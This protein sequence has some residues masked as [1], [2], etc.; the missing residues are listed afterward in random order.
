M[1]CMSNGSHLLWCTLSI[2]MDLLNQPGY[3]MLTV[4]W[5]K[6]LVQRIKINSMY[7]ICPHAMYEN[8][9]IE[10]GLSSAAA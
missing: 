3:Y 7:E 1:R 9:S 10:Q 8:R 5:W 2:A 4:L 6:V